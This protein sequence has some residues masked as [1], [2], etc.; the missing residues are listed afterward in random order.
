MSWHYWNFCRLPCYTINI[1]VWYINQLK[2]VTYR[3]GNSQAQK[4]KLSEKQFSACVIAK[5]CKLQVLLLNLWILLYHPQ[6]LCMRGLITWK[7]WTHQLISALWDRK[8]CLHPNW[9]SYCR[10]ISSIPSRSLEILTNSI[11]IL[12]LCQVRPN[13][14]I[15]CL[16]GFL[17]Q[18][19]IQNVDLSPP[20]MTPR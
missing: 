18:K 4:W 2:K 10:V 9:Q 16:R 14:I 1:C 8:D 6:I 12:A 3:E 15:L 20:P 13:N 11:C 7:N 5:L 19:F 17:T